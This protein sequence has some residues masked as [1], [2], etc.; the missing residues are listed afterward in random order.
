MKNTVDAAAFY[1]AMTALME[2]TSKSSIEVLREI[3]AEFT[4]EQCVLSA[5]D[6]DTWMSVT[7]QANGD[8]FDFVFRSSANIQ[9]V[10]RHYDGVLE[11]ELQQRGD[12]SFLTMRS[13]GKGGEFPAYDTKDCPI[14]PKLEVK[15]TYHETAY[16]NFPLPR[17]VFAFHVATEGKVSGC[18]MGVVADEKPTMETVMYRYPFS[19]VSGTRGA[20]CIGAN[21]LPKYKPPHALASLP[22]FLLSIPNGDH[23]F[24]AL[25]NKLNL[26]YR[27][28]LEH[29]KDKDPSYYYSDVLIPNGKTLKDFIGG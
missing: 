8:S 4:G 5:T 18:R 20:I 15:Q 24:N 13:G 21:A 3:K 19:N 7:I 16:P 17:L 27:D 12:E 28:L 23:S 26:Q 2:V 14:W 29:L 11:L 25:N 22:A 1:K 9:K 10:C 6:L